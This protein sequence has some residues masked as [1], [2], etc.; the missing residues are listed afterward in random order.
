MPCLP[1]TPADRPA[2]AMD[3]AESYDRAMARANG[4][5][6]PQEE[7][8]EKDTSEQSVKL[9]PTLVYDP[10]SV[11]HQMEAWMPDTIA[12]Y[13][14]KG[15]VNDFCGEVVESVPGMIRVQLG[16]ATHANASNGPMSWFGFRK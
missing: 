13:K 3:L 1:K 12:T 10:Q 2:S 14:L 7:E 4:E 15:F 5:L 11:I 6:G 16:G 9:G 8:P